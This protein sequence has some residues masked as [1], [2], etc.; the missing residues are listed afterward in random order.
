MRK[1]K[2]QHKIKFG[3]FRTSHY[4]KQVDAAF[5]RE[6]YAYLDR[7]IVPCLEGDIVSVAGR[8]HSHY[9]RARF[10]GLSEVKH[11]YYF[12]LRFG[13]AAGTEDAWGEV[14]YDPATKVWTPSR[15]KP[16]RLTTLSEKLWEKRKRELDH[17]I[18]MEARHHQPVRPA[19]CPQ[20]GS[21]RVADI[22]YGLVLITPDLNARLKSGRSSLGGCF[23]SDDNPQWHC[24]GCGHR[25]GLTARGLARREILTR[26]HEDPK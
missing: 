7:Q 23:V 19:K 6:F 15:I 18:S 24:A 16:C 3:P 9:D 21:K 25:W 11:R 26:M 22:V 1:A 5:R 13:S 14:D 4:R 17:R 20:C 12:E 2:F 10:N 8:V